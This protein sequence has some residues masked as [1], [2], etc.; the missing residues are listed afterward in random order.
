M[1]RLTFTAIT[2]LTICVCAQSAAASGKVSFFAESKVAGERIALDDIARLEGIS[3]SAL[4]ARLRSVDLGKSPRPTSSRTLSRSSIESQLKQAGVADAVRFVFPKKITVA[5]PGQ[6][7]AAV[8]VSRRVYSAALDAITE[9]WG[10]GY[11]VS[12]DPV[13][14][15]SEVVLPEGEVEVAARLREAKPAGAVMVKVNFR[16]GQGQVERQVSVRVRVTGP[17]CMARHDIERGRTIAPSDLVETRSEIKRDAL[18]CSAVVGQS[19][20]SLIRA[21]TPLRAGLVQAPKVVKRGDKVN[22][23]YQ[24]GALR[25]TARGEAMRDGA[26][27]DWITVVNSTSKK[28]IKARIEAAGNVSIQ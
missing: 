17:V 20:R 13:K 28:V 3:D 24:S 5:R 7:L 25:I 1:T 9:K 15:R 14:V 19:P 4:K 27:G 16:S 12:L 21:E 10:K 18:P 11:E 26:K 22:I 6:R 2:L 23:V 8:E